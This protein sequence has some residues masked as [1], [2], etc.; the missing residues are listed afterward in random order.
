MPG[1][2]F[3][4]GGLLL[5]GNRHKPLS[6][7]SI[8]DIQVFAGG[9]A[10]TAYLDIMKIERPDSPVAELN[11]ALRK[12]AVETGGAI[13]EMTK[14]Y[15]PRATYPRE[16]PLAEALQDVAR[17]IWAN[18]GARG[19]SVALGGFDTHTNEVAEHQELMTTLDGGLTAFYRDLEA[20]GKADDVLVL[21]WSEFGRRVAE[22]AG[23]GTDHGSASMAFALGKGV[24]KG[25][26]GDQPSMTE[27]IDNGNLSFT[28]DFRQVYATVIERWLGVDSTPLLGQRWEHV[29]F[30]A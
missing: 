29:P 6:L 2:D 17:V 5:A 4:G 3:G 7:G 25:L 18:M 16:N 1:I 12:Q 13:R 30:I 8:S 20:Q 11:R 23:G 9:E 15:T 19:F 26:H 21:T 27:M 28:T 24:N 10:L 14:D 22:N